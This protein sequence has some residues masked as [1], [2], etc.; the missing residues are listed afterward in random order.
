P[1]QILLSRRRSGHRAVTP[2]CSRRAAA[3][4]P[5][6][7]EAVC[8]GGRCVREAGGFET[9]WRWE[10]SPLVPRGS[11]QIPAATEMPRDLPREACGRSLGMAVAVGFEPTEEL[12]P[13]T[14]S[15]RAP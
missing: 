14:L 7:G 2:A 11:S 12:P 6:L 8:S 9:G 3:S 15:R 13:H 1:W 5:T 4:S 10:P